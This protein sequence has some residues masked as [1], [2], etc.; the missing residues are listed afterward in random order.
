MTKIWIVEDKHPVVPGRIVKVCATKA[1]A[2]QKAIELT[3]LMPR[4][5]RLAKATIDNWEAFIE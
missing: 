1:R 3:N 4:Q 5:G 2:E